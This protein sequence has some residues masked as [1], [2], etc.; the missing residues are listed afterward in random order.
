MEAEVSN[1]L[2]GTINAYM[3]PKFE[4][5]GLSLKSASENEAL[6]II[7]DVQIAIYLDRGPEIY[8]AI[9]ASGLEDEATLSDVMA[10]YL[11]VHEN[12]SYILSAEFSLKAGLKKITDLVID[13][14]IPLIKQNKIEGAIK[15]IANNRTQ[16]LLEYYE[17]NLDLDAEKAFS[18]SRYKDVVAIYYMKKRKLTETQAK[19]L[20][21][22]INALG[23]NK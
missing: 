3:L 15:T 14:I 13:N 12:G 23:K 7:D 2:K 4:N 22:A 8:A 20:S 17:N 5:A 10:Q 11:N 1:R 19:R 6:F 16:N 21:I 9:S 18:E